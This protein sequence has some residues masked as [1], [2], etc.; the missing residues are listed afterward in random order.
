M[1][2][3]KLQIDDLEKRKNN[4]ILRLQDEIASLEIIVE[5]KVF[6]EEELNDR[7]AS[8]TD[9]LG[10]LQRGQTDL[11][12]I[13]AKYSASASQQ[14][15]ADLSA[16]VTSAG[17]STAVDDE[18]LFCEICESSDHS[19]ADCPEVTS[20]STIFKQETSVDSSRPYCDNCESFSGHWTEDCPHGD[21]MF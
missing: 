8:L 20:A 11:P 16:G 19:I 12:V 2:A 5:D 4:E 7:I 18:G 17:I 13:P 10:R 1:A 6:G 14:H 3:L 9:E 21:E 15:S